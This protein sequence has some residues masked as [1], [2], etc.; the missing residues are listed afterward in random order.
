VTAPPPDVTLAVVRALDA[1]YIAHSS[2]IADGKLMLCGW[3]G[4]KDEPLVK[5]TDP[6]DAGTQAFLDSLARSGFELRAVTP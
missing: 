6:T 5:W 2:T 4:P 3:R 1:Y